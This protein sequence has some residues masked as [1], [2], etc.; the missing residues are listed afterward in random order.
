MQPFYMKSENPVDE[1]H[2]FATYRRHRRGVLIARC[3]Y[4]PLRRLKILWRSRGAVVM[5]R[6]CY[7][8]LRRCHDVLIG[9][10]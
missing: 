4:V 7:V 5:V 3:G 9:H 10:V 2:D 6:R 8:L 1:G